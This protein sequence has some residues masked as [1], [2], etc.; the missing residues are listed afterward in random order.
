MLPHSLALG[1]VAALAAVPAYRALLPASAAADGPGEA[2][3]QAAAGL[4][5]SVVFPA[6]LSAAGHSEEMLPGPA[7]A[8][9]LN[10]GY[11]GFLVGPRQ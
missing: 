8:A 9:V 6:A 10:A 2:A 1:G 4:G 11:F 7:I 3:G 5:F